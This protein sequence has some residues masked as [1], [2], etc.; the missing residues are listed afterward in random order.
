MYKNT[1][2]HKFCPCCKQ[3][4]LRDNFNKHKSRYDGCSPYCK[5]CE[6]N[7]YIERSNPKNGRRLGIVNDK[8]K[9]SCCNQWIGI[10]NFSKN[11]SRYD[12]LQGIC[13]ICSYKKEIEYRKTDK[14]KERDLRYRKS[15]KGKKCNKKSV[16]KYK[17][18][19]KYKENQL[20]RNISSMI[21][22]S[23]NTSNKNGSW[24]K[25][26]NWDI[27]ELKEH[28]EHQFKEGMSWDNRDKWHIDHIRPIASFNI[29]ANKCNDFKECWS[30]SNLQPLWANDNQS[31]GAKW[32]GRDYR[33]EI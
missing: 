32:K 26:V 13:K 6:H 15:E 33:Y 31:K 7:K 4:L 21:N 27:Q 8:K 1:D 23:L 18:S 3:M 22:Y 19:T 5:K 30:L 25:L 20:Y 16:T 12:G 10:E 29:T 17:K 11:K 28:L 2:T 14:G 9:C 24:T